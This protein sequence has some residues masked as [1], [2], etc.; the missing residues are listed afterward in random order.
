VVVVREMYHALVSPIISPL[1]E[2]LVP[3]CHVR[4]LA[5]D[6]ASYIFAGFV[7]FWCAIGSWA[8]LR[9]AKCKSDEY[10]SRVV[11][12]VHA[13]V[14]SILCF[15]AAIEEFNDPGYGTFGPRCSGLQQ[16]ALLCSA[17]YFTM[18]FLGIL[19]SSYFSWLFIGHHILSGGCLAF[20]GL[21]GAHGFEFSFV[22]FLMEVS[23]PFL[24]S[25]W[26]MIADKEHL[27]RKGR[28][29]LRFQFVDHCFYVIFFLARI[30]AGP[31]LTIQLV[32]ADET[33]LII[34]GA[35]LL[36]QVLSV[37][38]LVNTFSKRFRGD[39]WIN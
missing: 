11:S 22:T 10:G 26:L 14:S 25:R 23:N 12:V 32:F 27:K 15:V 5:V 39:L 17:G 30:I 16:I 34:K 2:F 6:E 19:L 29:S 3:Y 18:D 8:Y 7:V 9:Y 20:G 31:I 1:A 24:H 36:L 4:R 38:F 33:H 37:Q 35:G 28:G 13:I 21:F